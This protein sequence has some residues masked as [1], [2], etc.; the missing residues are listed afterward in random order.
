MAVEKKPSLNVQYHR[1]RNDSSMFGKSSVD[2]KCN[3]AIRHNQ[4]ITF[5]W[6]CVASMESYFESLLPDMDVKSR[7]YFPTC[8]SACSDI[9][10]HQ[11]KYDEFINI[12][13]SSL[14]A[15]C[16]KRKQCA[17]D[18]IVEFD[19]V[20]QAWVRGDG[21]PI[22]DFVWINDAFPMIND[23][24][25]L[26][27]GRERAED[28]E[29]MTFTG[30]QKHS[31][32]HEAHWINPINSSDI[33]PVQGFYFCTDDS[34]SESSLKFGTFTEA[35]Q[36]CSKIMTPN[37]CNNQSLVDKLK[38]LTLITGNYI[39][40]YNTRQRQVKLNLTVNYGYNAI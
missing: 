25:V 33:S 29:Y 1:N 2:F 8:D 39:F 14:E 31:W 13:L 24:V 28:A 38:S 32:R 22:L 23:L 37:I 9:S 15:F 36:S 21:S 5:G 16:E 20:E 30:P 26:Y 7:D 34:I 19:F 12:S 40:F 4:Q 27:L 17:F 18:V 10:G 3:Y 6:K 11:S 35:K